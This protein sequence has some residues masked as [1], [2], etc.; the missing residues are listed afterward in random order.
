MKSKKKVKMH[1][2]YSKRGLNTKVNIFTK[3]LKKTASYIYSRDINGVFY[4]ALARKLPNN[5]RI[6]LKGKNTGAAGTHL[7]YYGKWGTLGGGVS[8]NSKH[9]LD[10]AISEIRDE[11]HI[12]IKSQNINIKWL[13]KKTHSH[14]TLKLAKNKNGVGIFIF[15]IKDFN[16]FISLFPKFPNKRGGSDIVSSSLGEIDFVS[17]FTLYGLLR[18]Q[19]YEIKNKKNN[20]I[21]SYVV[22]TFNTHVIP[23]IKTINESV[24][25]KYN[26]KLKNIKDIRERVVKLKY[27]YKEV[28]DGVYKDIIN[29]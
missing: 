15:E 2:K 22:D 20:F 18:Q 12:D 23:Y 27:L 1:L 6:R 5:S 29:V 10:A 28:S 13:K 14:F 11:G 19:E 9:I 21:I 4:F 7:K 3:N 17:S 25:N 24:Y 16:Y 26:Y 8:S